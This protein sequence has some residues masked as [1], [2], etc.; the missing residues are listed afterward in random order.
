MS[1]VNKDFSKNLPTH[2]GSYNKATQCPLKCNSIHPFFRW[3]LQNT[4]NN[5]NAINAFT[6][7]PSTKQHWVQV[8]MY[9][10]T[11][12]IHMLKDTYTCMQSTYAGA[13]CICIL[14]M[15]YVRR[16]NQCIKCQA[17]GE[18]VH[19]AHCRGLMTNSNHWILTPTWPSHAE[20]KCTIAIR[21]L[22]GGCLL[23]GFVW[24]LTG[25]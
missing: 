5:V 23:S 21:T 25:F 19:I 20:M 9:V 15:M 24:E 4:R 12:I 13:T 18:I 1:T 14:D 7:I 22:I 10:R 2:P 3:T 16:Y 11:I 8:R 17:D 6:T